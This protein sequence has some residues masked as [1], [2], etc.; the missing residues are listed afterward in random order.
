MKKYS[1]GAIEQISNLGI[2]LN[3]L[4]HDVAWTDKIKDKLIPIESLL[5]V[6]RGERRG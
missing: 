3:S 2:T 1:I 4:F 5:T 6:K